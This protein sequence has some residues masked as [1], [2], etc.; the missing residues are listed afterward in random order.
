V[1]S[2]PPLDFRTCSDSSNFLNITRALRSTD[3]VSRLRTISTAVPKGRPCMART[4]A[5]DGS[6]GRRR[7]DIDCAATRRFRLGRMS[8]TAFLAQLYQACVRIAIFS[9]PFSRLP[10]RRPGCPPTQ[11]PSFP[12]ASRRKAPFR[13]R[14][15]AKQHAGCLASSRTCF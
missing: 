6:S 3:L 11:T 2:Q 1:L 9:P 4:T 10:P 12:S 14:S 15:Y 8:I 5:C 7:R 13:S